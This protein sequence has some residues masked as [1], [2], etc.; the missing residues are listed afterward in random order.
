M[1]RIDRDQIVR[2]ARTGK[3]TIECM[4]GAT[5]KVHHDRNWEKGF[6]QELTISV[7]PRK[8]SISFEGLFPR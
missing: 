8:E 5:S 3:V 4:I 6:E 7:W 2:L 1:C